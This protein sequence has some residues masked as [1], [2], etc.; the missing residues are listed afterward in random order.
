MPRPQAGSRRTKTASERFPGGVDDPDLALIEVQILHARY[1]DM[2]VNKFTQF[3]NC[4]KIVV[5]GETSPGVSE[6]GEVHIR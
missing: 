5:T 3:Y 4:A 1:W 2:K 6:V